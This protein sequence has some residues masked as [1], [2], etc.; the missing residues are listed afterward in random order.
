[1]VFSIA[2]VTQIDFDWKDNQNFSSGCQKFIQGIDLMK[3][4]MK[5]NKKMFFHCTTGEDRSGALAASYLLSKS[6]NADIIKIFKN[7]MCAKGYEGGDPDKDKEVVQKIRVGL[8]RT[9]LKTAYRIQEAKRK[10]LPISK[11]I[12]ETDPENLP[13]FKKYQS[14]M[15]FICDEA[16]G[17][18]HQ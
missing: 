8:T 15:N 6:K 5:Q 2:S 13:L 4:A 1:M 14:Q 3:A 7:E 16:P 17:L 9:F 11:K 12:C 10:N 18:Q